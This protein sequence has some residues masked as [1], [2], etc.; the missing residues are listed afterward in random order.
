MQIYCRLTFP[1]IQKWRNQQANSLAPDDS[2]KEEIESDDSDRNSQMSFS[3]WGADKVTLS[4]PHTTPQRDSFERNHSVHPTK[5][6][7]SRQ[8]LQVG[9][10]RAPREAALSWASHESGNS[11]TPS[12]DSED[13]GVNIYRQIMAQGLTSSK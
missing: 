6:Q 5:P 13:S 4:K 12:E 1:S 9:S 2:D 10:Q 3:Y 8:G 11:P 7:S